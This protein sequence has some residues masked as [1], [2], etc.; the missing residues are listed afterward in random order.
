MLASTSG[1]MACHKHRVVSTF[2][3]GRQHMTHLQRRLH[4]AKLCAQFAR[5]ILGGNQARLELPSPVHVAE[6]PR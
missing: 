6:E 1:G 3:T 4:P 5:L 2:A